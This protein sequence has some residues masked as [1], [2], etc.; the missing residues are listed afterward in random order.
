MA[1]L[2]RILHRVADPLSTSCKTSSITLGPH[3]TTTFLDFR[4]KSQPLVIRARFRCLHHVKQD[5]SPPKTTPK[6]QSKYIPGR[7]GVDEIPRPAQQIST[8][9]LILQ[10]IALAYLLSISACL[11][12]AGVQGWYLVLNGR[13]EEVEDRTPLSVVWGATRWPVDATRSLL[14]GSRTKTGCLTC[15]RRKTNCDQ[16]QP[17]CKSK[18]RHLGTKPILCSTMLRSSAGKN[19]EHGGFQCEGYDTRN[20]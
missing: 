14:S 4:S 1:N 2:T 9:L 19:C 20:E 18:K 7:P 13:A 15:R 16:G 8:P 5:H 17:Q 12:Y 10:R 11:A 6:D 3:A